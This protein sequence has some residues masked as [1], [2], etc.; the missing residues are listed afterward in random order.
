MLKSDILMQL[1]QSAER[2]RKTKL[3]GELRVR[4]LIAFPSFQPPAI[5]KAG[6]ATRILTGEGR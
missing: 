2:R 1:N 4:S 3:D 6:L 5:D